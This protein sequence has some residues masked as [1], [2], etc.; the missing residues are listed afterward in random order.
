MTN[1]VVDQ[2]KFYTYFDQF[3]EGTASSSVKNTLLLQT[4]DGVRSIKGTKIPC[5]F[6]NN[7]GELSSNWNEKCMVES[8]GIA[9]L[10]PSLGRARAF[11]HK[12]LWWDG[13]KV[14]EEQILTN[15]LLAWLGVFVICVVLL[16]SV[17]AA[18]YMLLSLV[19]INVEVL[20]SY[21]YLDEH[22]NYVTGIFLVRRVGD[23]LGL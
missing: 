23:C 19:C 15:V 9:G 22:V 12:Y 1:N 17:P 21:W 6:S 18:L 3:Y 20:G 8:R 10:D 4:T 7:A 14:V 13:L 16:G 2:A 11:V 5:R